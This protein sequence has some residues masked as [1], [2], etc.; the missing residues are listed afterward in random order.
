MSF[1]NIFVTIQMQSLNR[2]L[3]NE[4]TD[5]KLLYSP[6][7]QSV[8]NKVRCILLPHAGFKY[9]SKVL[10]NT[11]NHINNDYD[12]VVM[13][14]ANHF[15]SMSIT[16]PDNTTTLTGFSN[17]NIPL[18]QIPGVSSGSRSDISKEHS[19]QVDLVALHS[20]LQLNVPHYIVLVG[21]DYSK[22]IQP[23]ML[24]L[25]SKLNPLIIISSDFTHY[26]DNYDYTPFQSN[27]IENITCKDFKAIHELI[28][29]KYNCNTTLHVNPTDTICGLY[30]IKL[31]NIIKD[32][33]YPEAIPKI[34]DYSMSVFQDPTSDPTKSNVSYVGAIWNTDLL[35]ISARI[36]RMI[37]S[38]PDDIGEPVD[39]KSRI[40]SLASLLPLEVRNNNIWRSPEAK[41]KGVFVTIRLGKQLKGCIGI[42]ADSID[43]F[44][45]KHPEW[46]LL[47][48]IAYYTMLT[49]YEDPRFNDF[50]V[51]LR[52]DHKLVGEY[53]FA[54]NLLDKS[55]PT[56]NFR[57]DYQ[58]CTD[59]IILEYQGS[60]ATFLPSVMRDDFL[61][62]C[63]I[64]NWDSFETEVFGALL[65]KMGRS[66]Q[67]VHSSDFVN[68]RKIRLYSSK[69]Y[70]DY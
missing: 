17:N 54:V 62:G 12:S 55:R 59:G 60:E 5:T 51:P 25:Q 64:K 10:S 23:V 9:T 32:K 7:T 31:W 18:Q 52:N 20:L 39:R 46:N 30:A 26:G 47:H 4:W 6:V 8:Q 3:P 29:P 36:P 1:L 28:D 42:F 11:I 34:T 70:Y 19:F 40:I 63:D 66:K 44:Y 15:Q 38:L 57:Q 27:V 2:S 22:I 33:L 21:Q 16:T 24:V 65:E 69:E 37:I 13:L 41:S 45:N 43:H 68:N 50:E 53:S 56:S 35:S 48:L 49:L 14:C 61:H 58:V 67:L